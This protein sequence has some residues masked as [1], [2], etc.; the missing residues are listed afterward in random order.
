MRGDKMVNYKL[1][2]SNTIIDLPRILNINTSNSL[3]TIDKFTMEF[4]NEEELNLYLLNK[5]LI[6]SSDVGKPIRVAYNFNGKTNKLPV[7]YSNMKKCVND[8][9]YL[10]ATL[11]SHTTDIKFLE[12]LAN[13]YSLGSPKYN[14]QAVNVQ[15]I[16]CYITDVRSNGGKLFYSNLLDIAI[17]DLFVK[18]VYNLNNKT[19]ELKI[20]YRGV[21]DLVI[22]INRYDVGNGLASEKESIISSKNAIILG[23]QL[24]L[25]E[26]MN[27]LKK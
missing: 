27:T 14:P 8:L 20:N 2:V 25:V 12:K 10:K 1:M 4:T 13:H 9:L 18:A 17:N 15:D 7:T 5:G 3:Q 26:S 24:T 23:E 6:S 19:G 21:R 16:R 22:F 11:K